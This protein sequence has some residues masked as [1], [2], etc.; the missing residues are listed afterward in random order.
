MTDRTVLIRL[1]GDV[2][3]LVGKL[4]LA[5]AAIKGVTSEID[6]T[7]DR[8][9]W[10]AQSILALGPTLVPFAAAAVPVFAGLAAQMTLAIGAAGTLALGFAGMGDAVKALNEYQLEPTEA[11]FAK[12]RVEM[13]KMGTAGA[14]FVHFLDDL[15]PALHQLQLDAREG[16]LPGFEEGLTSM[17]G[18]LPRARAMVS[19]LASAIGDLMSQAGE[20]LA[21]GGFDDFFGFLD[22][23]AKP[24]LMELGQTIGNVM[25]GISNLFVAFEPL[26]QDFSGG[27]LDA[28]QAFE[29]WTQAGADG[30]FAD[31]IDYVEQSIPKAIDLI[32]SLSD[33]FVAIV[34]AA[35]PVGD[36]LLPLLSTFLEIIA[37]LAATPLGP[38]F[39]TAAAAMSIYGRAVAL[40]SITT[41]GLGKAIGGILFSTTQ[42][43]G[44]LKQLAADLRLLAVAGRGSG[45]APAA[46]FIGPLTEAQTAAQRTKGSLKELAG[47]AALI[48]GL[49]IATSGLGDSLGVA[50]TMSLALAGSF[51]GPLGA[52]IGAAIGAVLD[53]KAGYDKLTDTVNT[54]NDLSEGSDEMALT[55]QIKT[56]REQ[57]EALKKD[58]Q[59]ISG[60]ER[61][62]IIGGLF[63]ADETLATLT[64]KGKDL[65]GAIAGAEQRLSDLKSGAVSTFNPVST[66]ADA[67]QASA[68]AARAEADAIQGAT[69]A[70]KARRQE[71]LRNLN[72][73][74]NYQASIDDARKAFK[75]NGKT[76]DETT[77]KGRA[78]LTALYAM[79]EAWNGQGKAAKNAKGSLKAARDEFIKTATDMGFTAAAAGKLADRIFEIKSKKVTVAA[80]VIG[81]NGVETLN[82]ALSRAVSKTITLTVKRVGA[83][84]DGLNFDSGGWTGPGAKND[85]AGVVHADEVVLPK[86]IVRR[87]A[88]MLRSRYGFLPGMSGLPGYADGGYATYSRTRGPDAPPG[89]DGKDKG[90]H[91]QQV[92][93]ENMELLNWSMK[94]LKRAVDESEKAV[95][96]ERTARDGI[97]DKMSSLGGTVAGGLRSDIFAKPENTNPWAPAT[98][99]DPN[100]VLDADIARANEVTNLIASLEGK[101]LKGAALA[102]LLS[103]NDIPLMRAYANMSGETLAA[104]SAKFDAREKAL[105]VVSNAAGQAAYG[106]E[107]VAANAELRQANRELREI[108]LAVKAAQAAAAARAKNKDKND[109]KAGDRP[110]ANARRRRRQR[111][112]T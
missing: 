73:Q 1:K 11:N 60:A 105:G 38:I 64:G 92:L 58:Q 46:G 80:S 103:K 27:L 35:A 63:T 25:E 21:G 56:A 59:E 87:D 32:G 89:A 45:A 70:M 15:Q 17:V 77:E 22:R 95:D 55:A 33:A 102:E 93:I 3:D 6:T 53:L 10:L 9:A 109:D 74:L 65:D 16:M 72:A 2:G 29:K 44:G 112:H 52:G 83:A 97:L 19:D 36:V 91:P 96:K 43:S 28:S 47:T 67:F 7:N 107:L 42:A 20:N 31:F 51:A 75:E 111:S 98:A 88:A 84:L 34:T 23:N 66:L 82:A 78:N 76:I 37:M 86:Y 41:G 100:S 57:L 26:I 69:D 79:A 39:L 49:T 62:P 54:L 4:G 5:K 13:D 101:G 108:R 61:I 48:G 8:T 24:L 104:Y 12:M 50:N 14:H 68:D 106:G 30:G 71:T 81:L 90:K 85:V 40:A 94:R 18:L 99:T 110:A